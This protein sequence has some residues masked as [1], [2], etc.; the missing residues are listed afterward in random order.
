M[1]S[2]RSMLLKD[3]SIYSKYRKNRLSRMTPFK[4]IFKAFLDADSSATK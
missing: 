4:I 1:K 3:V 2:N